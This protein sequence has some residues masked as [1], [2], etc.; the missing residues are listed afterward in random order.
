MLASNGRVD[1]IVQVITVIVAVTL[2]LSGRDPETGLPV[3]GLILAREVVALT[4]AGSIAAAL[5]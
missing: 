3:K 5:G 2:V 4:T 1:I